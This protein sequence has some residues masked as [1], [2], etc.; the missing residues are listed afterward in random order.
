MSRSRWIGVVVGM[1]ILGLFFVWKSMESFRIWR[2]PE[3]D[4]VLI[5]HVRQVYGRSPSAVLTLR[6]TKDRKRPLSVRT[7]TSARGY[8][9]FRAGQR[10]FVTYNKFKPDQVLVGYVTLTGIRNRML[11]M[12]FGGIL[13]LVAAGGVAYWIREREWS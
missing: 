1:L 8:R 7:R 5:T 11:L 10:V 4:K 2:N 13:A 12:F 6:L 9:G 3:R